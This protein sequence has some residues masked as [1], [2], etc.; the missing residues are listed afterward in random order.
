MTHTHHRHGTA[1]SLM[2]DWV[3]QL[4][5]VKGVNDQDA[6]AKYQ[7]FL[8]LSLKYEPVNGGTSH[9]GSALTLGWEKLIAEVG[10]AYVANIMVVFDSP[11]KVAKFL[12]DLEKAELGISVIVS[13]LHAETDKICHEVGI[14]RHTVQ[15]SLG[16]WGKRDLLPDP[17][18]VEI[19]TMCGHGMIPFNLVKS[20]SQRV[21]RGDI[22]LERASEEL[23]KPCICGIFN[24]NR[25]RALITEYI[26][27][28]SDN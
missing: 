2:G 26:S 19:S 17:K 1:E 20:M 7:E 12:V 14:K 24:T 16:I 6:N 3:V 27:A 23:S 21:H 25:A 8:R 9:I 5:V 18:I 15:H 22:S 4:L 10:K 11:E 28:T 13:G